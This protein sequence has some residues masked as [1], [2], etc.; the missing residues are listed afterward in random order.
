VA[1][2]FKYT[3]S[4]M[5]PTTQPGEVGSGICRR[6]VRAVTKRSMAEG[7]PIDDMASSLTGWSS[8]RCSICGLLFTGVDE[9]MDAPMDKVLLLLCAIRRA[10][11]SGTAHFALDGRPYGRSEF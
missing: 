10:L 1:I 8:W 6:C 4:A 9:V 7:Q 3:T 5:R 2:G 11:E